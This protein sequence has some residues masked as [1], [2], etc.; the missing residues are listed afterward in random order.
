M[1]SFAQRLDLLI[2]VG[3]ENIDAL[4]RPV[5]DLKA[6][7]QAQAD[8]D[9]QR[10]RSREEIE[11][12]M[13]LEKELANRIQNTGRRELEL[14]RNQQRL[15][16]A[17]QQAV[18]MARQR[19]IEE[20]RLA[21][22]LDQLDVAED[23]LQ[24]AM[25]LT[26]RRSAE[27]VRLQRELRRVSDRHTEAL[28][29]QRREAS[30]LYQTMRAGKIILSGIAKVWN[31]ITRVL[32]S[33]VLIGFT[34]RTVMRSIFRFVVGPLKEITENILKS[35]DAFRQ[36]DASLVGV[37][38]SMRGVRDLTADIAES[39]QGLPVTLLQATQGIRGLAFTPGTAGV[40]QTPGPERVENIE[41]LMRILTGL[42]TI[43]PEQG[44]MGARFAV[45]E[46][47]AGEFRS[48]RFR[49]ELSPSVIA[50]G[51]GESLENL[52]ADPQLTLDALENFVDSFIGDEAFAEFERLLSVQGDRFKGAMQEFF[53][54]I[55][56]Q[57]IYDEI[58][59][60][61]RGA[62]D[63]ISGASRGESP[64][65]GAAAALINESLSFLFREI[66]IS[67]GEAISELTG[68]DVDLMNL[69]ESTVGDLGRSVAV[70]IEFLSL[71]A[72]GL[73]RNVPEIAEF[74]NKF[75]DLGPMTIEGVEERIAELADELR[76]PRTLIVGPGATPE[77]LRPTQERQE[78]IQRELQYERE[79][80]RILRNI[81]K[82]TEDTVSHVDDQEAAAKRIADA[83]AEAIKP[84]SQ[85]GG[86]LEKMFDVIG[87]YKPI[88]LA[89]A[90]LFVNTVNAL[91]AES[92]SRLGLAQS[93]LDELT[94]REGQLLDQI[95]V[96]PFSV[97]GI[98][99]GF[100]RLI[101]EVAEIDDSIGTIIRAREVFLK[102][103]NDKLQV[104]ARASIQDLIPAIQNLPAE[105]RIR[106]AGDLLEFLGTE[107]GLLGPDLSGLGGFGTPLGVSGGPGRVLGSGEPGALLQSLTSQVQ[108]IRSRGFEI[109]FLDPQLLRE[110][111]LL[112]DDIGTQL[113]DQTD[114]AEFAALAVQDITDRWLEW[115]QVMASV[116]EDEGRANLFI[117]MSG[118][119][120]DLSAKWGELADA[121]RAA[122]LEEQS[123][124]AAQ[125]LKER[126]QLETQAI[127]EA[128]KETKRSIDLLLNSIDELQEKSIAGFDRIP[129][130]NAP[131]LPAQLF[132]A[133]EESFRTITD[134][135]NPG[136]PFQIGL[137]INKEIGDLI[138]KIEQA[139][140]QLQ[141][142]TG[143]EAAT[144][145]QIEKRNDQLRDQIAGYEDL[146]KE[147][148]DRREAIFRDAGLA[149][150]DGFSGLLATIP[151]SGA[152]L[153]ADMQLNE[154]DKIIEMMR[155]IHEMQQKMEAA[156]LDETAL[157][158]RP[159]HAQ[160]LVVLLDSY[161]K[162]LSKVG[163]ET[164][165]AKRRLSDLADEFIEMFADIGDGAPKAMTD[166]ITQ[167]IAMIEEWEK[168]MIEGADKVD[169]AYVSAAQG[170][171]GAFQT[172]LV[173]SL[174]DAINNGAGDIENILKN[175]IIA[176]QREVFALAIEM[177]II[178]GLVNPFVNDAFNLSGDQALPTTNSPST[179]EF[180]NVVG[181]GR[182][183]EPHEFGGVVN[184]ETVFPLA[185]SRLGSMAETEPEIIFPIEQT[186]A[187]TIGI[188]GQGGGTTVV[189]HM[190][191]YANDAQSFRRSEGEIVGSIRRKLGRV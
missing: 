72:I 172:F 4:R 97:E 80:L 12:L 24:R 56:D 65:L 22:Q 7:L 30:L 32:A 33:F 54:L 95:T 116:A 17:R 60:F 83:T 67:A 148:H 111:A 188:R 150:G 129:T 52:K 92:E 173:D 94:V 90:E 159:E 186:S 101:A 122:D 84:L 102:A 76:G 142:I 23:K 88:D 8:L 14:M 82:L 175:L 125:V 179:S 64:E 174:V 11:A 184:R 66:R 106:R 166:A 115:A 41:R 156:G 87:E 135:E 96:D 133:F 2:E 139:Q 29:R 114:D 10:G 5:R 93:K 68:I 62:A 43:D 27:R 185:N 31:G 118:F 149:A 37:V 85:F 1:S 25:R 13:R 136:S 176:I 112:I 146:I 77:M 26:S 131:L 127:S 86:Q 110:V 163:T 187:G 18:N 138:L 157:G 107:A 28:R 121:A 130:T 3:S 164:D 105:L 6:L 134:R 21:E 141:D 35:T 40:I 58:T 57:G 155:S 45:R 99:E 145:E 50:A 53:R 39:T 154:L 181:P 152:G 98:A 153:P 167:S 73:A 120:T 147:L 78:E 89:N 51:I 137:G 162:N 158:L 44:I 183:I 128:V 144:A 132:A 16:A 100:D 160:L 161:A 75:V 63:I 117:E 109:E 36:L 59:T 81:A 69:D 91:F 168:R 9:R 48:L 123:K 190:K 178:R 19:R 191:V 169:E 34:A 151:A 49:F 182:Y 171:S 108:E 70:V 180:G 140:A 79:K 55:G 119:L 177:S 42:A 103:S 170:I 124:E 47:L 38:G 165:E 71:L 61:L 113:R 189:V 143:L 126:L 74:L 104:A 20:A 15:R 46:A